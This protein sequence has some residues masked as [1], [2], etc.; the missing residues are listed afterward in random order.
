MY[1]IRSYYGGGLGARYLSEDPQISIT[2]YSQVLHDSVATAWE[3]SDLGDIPAIMVEPGRS[4]AAP[5]AITLYRVG[6][7]S[8]N[9]V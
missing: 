1:A 8:Y 9:F 6:T 3:A 4:I 7:I 5:S 2:A